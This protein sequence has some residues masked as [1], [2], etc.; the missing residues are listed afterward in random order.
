MLA[1]EEQDR[2]S[3]F[4]AEIHRSRFIAGRV[5]L[6]EIL[7]AKLG[8]PAKEVQLVYSRTGKPAL[9]CGSFYFNLAHT[10]S[11]GLLAVCADLIG[12]DLEQNR[13][14]EFDLL[15][16]NVF[17]SA[18]LRLWDQLTPFEKP[19]AFYAIWTRK[20]ALLKAIGCGITEHVQNV[21]V[22][23]DNAAPVIISGIESRLASK[24]WRIHSFALGSDL[25]AAIAYSPGG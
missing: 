21:S 4:R 23:F 20:E 16:R 3:R 6:R 18:E 15:A 25:P 8:C 1:P 11:V 19:S 2:A 7:G 9:P 22:F 12:T 24:P 5:A 13:P 10:G 14:I 17:S